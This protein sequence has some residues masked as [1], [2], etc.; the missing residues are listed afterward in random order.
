MM[1]GV[2][3]AE[4]T[5]TRVVTLLAYG[6]PTQA[7]VH[8]YGL[9]ER[10]VA[11]WQKRAGKQ[12]Q[13]VHH[14]IVEQGHV[15]SQHIQADE[16]RAKGRKLIIWI[17]LAMDVTTRLWM[18]GVV[19][20]SRD[21]RLIDRLFQHVRACCQFVQA[22][23]VCTDGFAAYPNSIVRVFR[24]KVKKKEGRGRCSLQAWPDLC[25]ATVI[26]RTEK[27]RVVEVTRKI[28]RGALTKA[29]ELL[30][31]TVGCKEF[32]TSFI[33]RLNATMRER[34]ASLTRKCRHAVQRLETLE[35][36]MF[37]IGCTYNFCFPHHELSKSTHFGYRCTPA[38]A[39]GL[40]DHIW[41]IR[42]LL[43]YKVAP[44]AWVEPKR[45]GRPRKAAGASPP[46]PKRP[47]GRP[48]THPLPDPSVPKRPRGR[49]RKV[50]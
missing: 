38:M 47:R 9:D 40:T 24:E 32:N 35:A 31:R 49:P 46:L 37:L 17:A 1:E 18:A 36:G 25:I 41:R 42:E 7:I 15:E 21:R 43:L 34:L 50:A 30:Q 29:Q 19:S 13:R 12:C 44:V 28:T 22:L 10:T 8:A 16:I 14:A 27:K 5:V 48:R 3:T 23:L 39:A 4:E 26:K 11:D 6:C 20:T 2:R 45:S 33:E